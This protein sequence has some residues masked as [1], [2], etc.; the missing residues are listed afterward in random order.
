MFLKNNSRNLLIQEDL[1]I[2]E[3]ESKNELQ[4]ALKQIKK[5]NFELDKAKKETDRE[6]I[7]D[8]PINDED[9]SDNSE[10]EDLQQRLSVV[11]TTT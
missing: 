11:P 4:N 7:S 9:Y 2:L 8:E 10:E 6:R 3:N 5:L 1:E